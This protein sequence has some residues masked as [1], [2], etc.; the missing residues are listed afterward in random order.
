MAGGHE[1]AMLMKRRIAVLL[2][3]V[4]AAS[5]VLL[6]APAQAQY[7]EVLGCSFDRTTGEEVV[8]G[9]GDGFVPNTS[10][11]ITID[12]SAIP[13]LS[14]AALV[15]DLGSTIA[16][17]DGVVAFSAVVPEDLDGGSY[18]MTASGEAFGGGTRTLQCPFTVD[19]VLPEVQARQVAFT[20]SNSLTIAS[21]ALV[22]IGVG[23]FALFAAKRR[24]NTS[25]DA[26]V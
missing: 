5:F 17:A 24:E 11:A 19:E 23:A 3:L 8:S 6:A 12:D 9:E 13:L 4:L 26:G 25:V 16:D 1:G 10:V 14:S 2:S 18:F 21:V 20:G 7:A 22:L 15:R